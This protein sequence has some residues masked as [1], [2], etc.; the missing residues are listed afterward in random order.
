[1]RAL[2][3]I[4]IIVV[5]LAANAHAEDYYRYPLT[6]QGYYPK[7]VVADAPQLIRKY[8]LVN[9]GIHSAAKASPI[10][11]NG[12][13]YVGADSGTFYAINESDMSVKWTFQV[14]KSAAEG[15]HSTAAI[16]ETRV[17]VGDYAGWFYALNKQTG[18]LEWQAELGE[19]IGGSPVIWGDNICVGVE[20]TDPDGYLTCVKRATGEAV[21]QS[22][23]FGEHTH[24]TPTI[25]TESGHI[26]IGANSY[27]FYCID[28]ED[29]KIL[30]TVRT[31]GE[32]KSTP[33]LFD[34]YV[35][36][37]S[38]DTFLWKVDAKT[39]AVVW[40]FETGDL[41]MSSPAVDTE[42]R[43][44]YFGSHDKNLYAVDFDSGKVKWAFETEGRV[45]SSPTIVSRAGGG[46]M[47]LVGSSDKKLYAINAETGKLIWA[48]TTQGQVSSVPTVQNG[49]IYV[50]GDDGW[51]YV[52]Q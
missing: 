28:S 22:P 3:A 16:D 42:T 21:L 18:R 27:Y 1:M 35:L 7:E 31:K 39:G 38:W 44:V 37:T 19:S 43:T 51:L 12:V 41:S 20:V 33:A 52:F 34:G 47:V 30:W 23:R 36:F 13:I 5:V 24:S 6:H 50:S 49:K 10:V 4:P 26:F 11:E 29:G 9:V 40:K 17:Y 15:I 32:I 8:G 14:R 25:D 2:L 48:Y 46:K 45:I